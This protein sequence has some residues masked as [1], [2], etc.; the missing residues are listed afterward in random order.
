MVKR[1]WLFFA[2]FL[3][4]CATYQ[5]L[6]VSDIRIS[7]GS[8]AN[9]TYASGITAVL[10]KKLAEEASSWGIKV[11]PAERVLSGEITE[12]DYQPLF[13]GEDKKIV[14]LKA[15]IKVKVKMRERGKTVWDKEFQEEVVSFP[16]G[17]WKE[18]RKELLERLCKRVAQKIIFYL[19]YEQSNRHL[20]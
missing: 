15:K 1:A 2:I 7:I 18:P 13:Y 16:Q 17:S 19:R 12:I 9:L 11:G 10:K 5:S 6:P 20:R 3:S 8:F 14:G 4:G